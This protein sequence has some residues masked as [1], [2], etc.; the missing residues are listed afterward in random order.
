M[1]S[2][3][4][5]INVERFFEIERIVLPR[6]AIP[7]YEKWSREDL[8]KA[9]EAHKKLTYN[10]GKLIRAH[11]FYASVALGCDIYC[12]KDIPTAGTDDKR[13]VWN[14]DFT[15]NLSDSEVKGVIAHEVMHIALMHSLRMRDRDRM[16]WNVACDYAI[17][18]QLLK[19]GFTLPEKAL[20]DA[21][22]AEQNAEVI[23]EDLLSNATVVRVPV[24]CPGLFGPPSTD[25]GIPGLGSGMGTGD[26]DDDGDQS[27]QQDDEEAEMDKHDDKDKGSG[28]GTGNDTSAN[29]DALPAV[30]AQPWGEVYPAAKMSEQK[31]TRREQEV[32]QQV[33]QAA[34]HA[35]AIGADKGVAERVLSGIEDDTNW[36]D[37]LR[38]FV[39]TSTDRCDFSWNRPNKRHIQSGIY[40][41]HMTGERLEDVIIAIDTSGSI[42]DEQLERFGAAVSSLLSE[43]E[44]VN[45]KLIY[46]DSVI[47]KTEELTKADLPL[48]LKCYGGGG[49]SF[50]PP[51]NWVEENAEQCSV[52]L[53]FT[54]LWCDSFPEEPDYDVA[55]IVWGNP[56]FVNSR[57]QTYLKQGK[58][59]PPFGQVIQ[60]DIPAG[61]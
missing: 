13:I 20:N 9:L 12:L 56:A 14:P 45:I 58:K 30:E 17:N 35:V 25:T 47:Q 48:N 46:C 22:Y 18:G 3:G 50:R 43:Y 27:G 16:L 23:Y 28:S 24:G 2:E 40:L 5:G 53:Y 51:F 32:R 34:L 33:E 55:W 31:R 59:F 52:F 10:M 15:I 1:S 4:P 29:D 42:S 49:T 60:M 26:L 57:Q 54:D 39:K 44:N 6:V 19:E 37:L 21:K 36:K 8:M 41:P 11:P 38:E 7:I 61:S